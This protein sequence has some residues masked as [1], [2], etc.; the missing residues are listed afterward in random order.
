[1]DVPSVRVDEEE[2]VP[3][4]PDIRLSDLCSTIGIQLM[5][6][7][8][9]LLTSAFTSNTPKWW[10]GGVDRGQGSG[11]GVRV[12]GGVFEGGEYW[13][14]DTGWLGLRRKREKEGHK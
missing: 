12:V 10:M 1:M 14:P 9:S 4:R 2:G 6:L 5:D 8:T 7:P 3:T 13:Y 11:G